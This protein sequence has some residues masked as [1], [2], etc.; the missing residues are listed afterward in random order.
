MNGAQ[1]ST[2]HLATPTRVLLDSF[3]VCPHLDGYGEVAQC[4][5]ACSRD[6]LKQ[7]DALQWHIIPKRL[8]SP[9]GVGGFSRSSEV[10]CIDKVVC[11]TPVSDVIT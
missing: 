5:V 1:G 6:Y 10:A 3:R 4:G 7:S 11:E 9:C 8:R 2:T